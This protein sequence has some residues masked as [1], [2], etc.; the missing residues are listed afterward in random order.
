MAAEA[1]ADVSKLES[2]SL[3]LSLLTCFLHICSSHSSSSSS[4]SWSCCIRFLKPAAHLLPKLASYISAAHTPP[5][6]P[7][8]FPPP[9]PPLHPSF[10]SSSSSS[11][12][13]L[14]ASLTPPGSTSSFAGDVQ[15][16]CG[17]FYCCHTRLVTRRVNSPSL[18]CVG[19]LWLWDVQLQ[20]LYILQ[21]LLLIVFQWRVIF[22]AAIKLWFI[23]Q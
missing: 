1:A 16:S 9:H 23:I 4:F 11:L 13:R 14:Q 17:V 6:P 15:L 22:P 5:P 10:S 7:P 8:P 20:Y 21:K 2:K 3:L 19:L 12:A 18:V